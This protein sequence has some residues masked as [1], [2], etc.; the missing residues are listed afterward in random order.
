MHRGFLGGGLLSEL[1]Q[2]ISTDDHAWL[3]GDT[4]YVGL[5]RSAQHGLMPAAVDWT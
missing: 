4:V 2:P 3:A 1:V 5:V